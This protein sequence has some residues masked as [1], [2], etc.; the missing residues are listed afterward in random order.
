[1]R[2][3]FTDPNYKFI[4]KETPEKVSLRQDMFERAIKGGMSPESTY[5]WFKKEKLSYRK[6]DLLADFSRAKAIEYSKTAKAE[7][8][9]VK[10]VNSMEKVFKEK[11]LKHREDAVIFMDKW[12]AE[13]AD[14][15]YEAQQMG[16]KDP[17]EVYPSEAGKVGV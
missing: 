14:V 2:F 1:M 10:W 4:Y 17:F 8:K 12:K 15:I 16:V 6:T 7:V 11:K 9:A 3:G 13:S 5:K